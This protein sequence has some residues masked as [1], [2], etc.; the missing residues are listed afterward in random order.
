MGEHWT[1][2]E[3]AMARAGVEI[4]ALDTLEA[5]TAA[6]RLLD[7][8]WEIPPD[9][10]SEVRPSLL[11][12]L[13]HAGNYLT[14]AY[15]TTG[16]RAG[17][18]VAAS[19]AFFAAPSDASMHSHITGVL[20]GS[21]HGI[22]SAIKWHQRAWALDRGLRRITWTYDPLIARNAFFNIT[23]LGA[24]PE[25][26]F[27]DFYGPMDD[28]PNRGQPTDRADAIWD[29][30]S[31]STARAAAGLLESGPITDGPDI[32]ALLATGGAVALSVAAS[33]EP[34][35]GAPGDGS[36]AGPTG[37]GQV[38]IG[39]PADIEAIRRSDQGR[40][41]RWRLAL[42]T[43]LAPLLAEDGWRVTGFAKSGWY[44]LDRGEDS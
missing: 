31:D 39:I 26:Y 32:D 22:G 13:D 2:A 3:A 20:A 23:R 29:L 19:V 17:T 11:R 7:D 6:C 5:M 15:L 9:E 34:E 28:G 35:V 38:L 21:G 1:V 44:V 42:R 43:A 14:G 27:V 24:R 12:G 36:T 33:G 4:R 18:M 25:R 16:P 8:V 30:A 40:A 41:L 10:A 37:S